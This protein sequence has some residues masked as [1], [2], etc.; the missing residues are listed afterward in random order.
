MPAVLLILGV[1]GVCL[2]RSPASP[3]TVVPG[4]GTTTVTATTSGRMATVDITSDR[5][6]GSATITLGRIRPTR[7]RLRLHLRGL[8]QCTLSQG[9]TT[10]G[11]S[12][13][14]TADHTIRRWVTHDHTELPVTASDPRWLPLR[15]GDDVYVIDVPQVIL[16][17]DTPALTVQWVDFF[18]G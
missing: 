14:S 7:L 15:M 6:I 8:E 2:W 3:I 13:A 4:S 9:A 17:G 18:R 12:V 1:L 5:G 11:L 16:T 10:L